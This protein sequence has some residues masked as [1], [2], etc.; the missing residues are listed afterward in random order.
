ME[1]NLMIIV[2][3]HLSDAMV[4]QDEETRN[5]HIRFAKYLINKYDMN[6]YIDPKKVFKLFMSG[7]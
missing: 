5:L 7:D 6:E 2:Q 1:V 3:S 4:C